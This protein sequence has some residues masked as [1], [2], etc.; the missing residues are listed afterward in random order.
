MSA[1]V[2][3]FPRCRPPFLEIV[4]ESVDGFTHAVIWRDERYRPIVIWRG[5]G[6]AAAVK[7][8]ADHAAG[9]AGTPV[10]DRAVGGAA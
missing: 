9:F 10:V 6:H 2:L 7:R 3:Q 4:T 1:A 5:N 8:I